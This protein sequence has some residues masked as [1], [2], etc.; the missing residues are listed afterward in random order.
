M[1]IIKISEIVGYH[2]L[3]K[4]YCPNCMSEGDLL[5]VPQNNVIVA[6]DLERDQAEGYRYYC[7]E[8]GEMLVVPDKD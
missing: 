4:I 8:C 3:N 1:S 5:N 7:D 6:D 2:L